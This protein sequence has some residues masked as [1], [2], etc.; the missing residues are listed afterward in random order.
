MIGATQSIQSWPE[1][2]REAA[3]LVIDQ[4][5]EPSEMTDSQLVWHRPGPWKRIV[6]GFRRYP[7]G[8]SNL[9]PATVPT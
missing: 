1:E 5:G 9:K 7:A 8:H 2:A 4:Y 6:C 3:Q